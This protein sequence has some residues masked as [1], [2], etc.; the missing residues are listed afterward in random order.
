MWRHGGHIGVQNNSENFFGG[1][2]LILL[3]CKTGATF[4]HCFVHQHGCHVTWVKYDVGT[5]KSCIWT[6]DWNEVWSMWRG[7][8]QG[9]KSPFSLLSEPISP[10]SL[11][12]EP[13]SPSSL[14][15]Y[16]TFSPSSL[17]FLGHFSLPILFLPRSF[18]NTTAAVTR[19]IM[20]DPHYVHLL[21]GLIAQLVEH[22]TGIA[23]GRIQ[24]PF[25]S[26]SFTL[27]K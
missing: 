27:H 15:V 20:I 16:L 2:N 1:G 17:L 24:I 26:L 19:F 22:S 4:C 21:V 6:A 12:L 11:I 9:I 3:L 18:S 23:D 7:E 10:S 14:N 13:I 5:W 25:S 8:G